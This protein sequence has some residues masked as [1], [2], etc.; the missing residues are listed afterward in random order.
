MKIAVL[1]SGHLRT[2]ERCK[3]NHEKNYITKD[4]D[5]YFYTYDKPGDTNYKQF[6]QI[7]GT[8][9]DKVE[10]RYDANKNPITCTDA[11]LQIWHNLFVGFCLVPKDYDVYVKSRCDIELSGKVDF[12]KYDIKA[13]NVYI[14]YGND[15]CGGI[16]DQFAFGNYEVMKKYYSIYLE[17]Q[18]LFQAGLTFHTEYYVTENLKKQ[19]V[20]IVRLDITDSI[21]REINSPK[22]ADI[23]TENPHDHW[24]FLE[25]K[26]NVVLDLGCGRTFNQT[27]TT[28]E[29]FLQQGAK[30]VIGVEMWPNE[31]EWFIELIKDERVFFNVDKVDYWQK[32]KF[33]LKFCNINIIKCDIEGDE[34]MFERANSEDLVNV[35][36]IAFEYHNP[37]MKKLIKNNYESWGFKD[38]K[39]MSMNGF[40]ADD[41]GVIH[42]KK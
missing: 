24:G 20:N 34:K 21:V 5:L 39:I 35:K 40:N 41:Q 36:E 30:Q 23:Q 32:L 26:D 16:N 9:Y 6:I 29:Y 28:P 42:I 10:H 22:M 1:Y 13:N 19:G 15:H 11:T 4:C 31:V 37:D 27:P 25:I 7:P 14:P 33:Y 3:L 12:S 8:Y 2:W 18:N 17:H 38:I